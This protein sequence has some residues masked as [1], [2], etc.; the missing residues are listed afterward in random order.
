MVFGYAGLVDSLVDRIRAELDR[1]AKV[2]AT[3]GL[4]HVIAS[5][6]KSIR[7]IEPFLTLEGLRLIR[8]RNRGPQ[9]TEPRR[10]N[11]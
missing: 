9:A 4:A 7:R 6:T 2:I 3:G 11:A 5:E 8:E 1:D 10:E